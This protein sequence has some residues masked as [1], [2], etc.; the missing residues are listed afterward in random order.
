[1]T[2][3]LEPCQAITVAL[4]RHKFHDK[5]LV[6]LAAGSSTRMSTSLGDAQGS[7]MTKCMIPVGKNKR[8]FLQYLLT[9]AEKAGFREVVLVI[10]P[11]D[12]SIEQYFGNKF[13]SINLSRVVQT[14]PEGR[15]KPAGTADALLQVLK[16]R[17]LWAGSSFCVCNS[18]N[19]YSTAILNKLR[20][21][22]SPVAMPC[23]D[24]NGLMYPADRT[25]RFAVVRVSEDFTVLGII[26]KPN[27]LQIQENM[28]DGIVYASMNLFKL[29]YKPAFTALENV[30]YNSERNEKELPEAVQLLIQNKPGCMKGIPLSEH[31]PDLTSALDIEAV[32]KVISH[33]V[34]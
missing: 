24:R 9:N 3:K 13:G 29:N 28:V 2:E 23:Y 16:A 5:V 20:V 32:S 14:V 12:S 27:D 25:S 31:V 4:Y 34:L 8:P 17:P 18:D 10:A 26:E 1:M 19:L 21:S 11:G 30:P 33:K 6:I 7:R 22:S 15:R